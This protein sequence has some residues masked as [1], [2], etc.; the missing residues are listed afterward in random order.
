M[1]LIML[2]GV[3]KYFSVHLIRN[4]HEKKKKKRNAHEER[5]KFLNVKPAGVPERRGALSKHFDDRDP[6][7]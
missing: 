6:I 3:L 5:P 7:S 4:A 1:F 2:I